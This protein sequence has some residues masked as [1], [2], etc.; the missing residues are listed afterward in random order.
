MAE[1]SKATSQRAW[2]TMNMNH[3]LPAMPH[4]QP[5]IPP[6]RQ[7]DLPYATGPPN[8]R[9]PPAYM[10]YHLPMNG[11]P[12]PPYSPQ[13][14]QWYPAYPQQ[15][16]MPPRPY[17][18][19]YAP[20]IVSSYP[21]A[22]QATM[23]P[24]HIPPPS[25]H[26]QPRTPTPLQPTM[27]PV[28]PPPPMEIPEHPPVAGVPVNP[29]PA[30]TVSSPPPAQG[31]IKGLPY[32][33]PLPGPFRAPVS[34]LESSNSPSSII[35]LIHEQ[36]PWLSVP[37]KPFPAR[38]PRKRRTKGRTLQSVAVELPAKS[39]SGE[40]QGA[41]KRVG[42]SAQAPS[43]PQTPT[44]SAGPSD[45]NSTQPTTPSS[46]P[47]KSSARPQSQSK[48][49]KP[50]VPIVP[51]VPVVPH[52]SDT[53]RQPAKDDAC[54]AA[55]P[56]K[57]EEIA[58]K[59]P[60]E[61]AKEPKTD[62]AASEGTEKSPSPPRAAPKSWADL[63]RSKTS[64]KA[65]ATPTSTSTETNGLMTQQRRSIADVLVTLGDDVAQYGDKVAFLEPRGLVN[66][67]NMCY[68]NSV[69][70]ILSRYPLILC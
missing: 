4:G 56:S 49:S 54:H 53:P 9:S 48:G 51:V 62:T 3:N 2:K 57:S 35:F 26:L 5:P 36:V 12:P 47:Q 7:Q 64:G 14:P 58:V 16:Q 31:G 22:A 27:S 23:P 46:A 60:A 29:S 68:M 61:A 11:H 18:P 39:G 28:G 1:R 69:C 21:P 63:V 70:Y 24:A 45:A 25:L 38:A 17:Q 32:F 6:R 15:M 19:P 50:A 65:T 67:G 34:L 30:P 55:E 13:Y 41:V 10:G 40:K 37:E 59:A 33:P 43:E 66:T 42:T 52:A 8:M 44:L 20:M